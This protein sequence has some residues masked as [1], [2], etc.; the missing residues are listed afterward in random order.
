M[1]GRGHGRTYTVNIKEL[2]DTLKKNRDKHVGIVEEAQEE[3]RK[4]AIEEIER[5][6]A[7]AKSGK[8]I[9]T[10]LSL[11]VPSIHT[12][13][14]DNAIGLMEMTM[15]AKETTIEIDAHEYERFVRNNW[16][17]TQ[18]FRDSNFAY[19]NKLGA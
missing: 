18:Q 5:A 8:K 4:L 2:V 3:F 11:E 16:E 6:L 17:W 15:R 7:D 9:V 1:I 14:F 10:R 13:A 12:D 19:S